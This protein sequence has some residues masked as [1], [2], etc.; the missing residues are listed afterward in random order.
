MG[1]MSGTAFGDYIAGSNHVLPTGG[2]GRFSS[3]LAPSVYLR[4]QEVIEIPDEAVSRLAAPLAALARAEGLPGHARSA[5]VRA[6]RVAAEPHRARRSGNVTRT[7]I[8]VDGAPR[9]VRRRP[10]QPG[11]RRRRLRVLRRSGAARPRHRHLV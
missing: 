9:P 11:D 10:L 1:A 7:V 4:I 8:A 3:G 5:E 6:E 2:R